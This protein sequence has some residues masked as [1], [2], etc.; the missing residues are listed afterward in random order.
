VN[1]RRNIFLVVLAALAV[2]IV[3]LVWDYSTGDRCLDRGGRWDKD[4]GTCIAS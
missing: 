4:A 1:R 2:A 3:F